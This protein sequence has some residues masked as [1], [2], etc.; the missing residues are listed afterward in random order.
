M[1]ENSELAA[2]LGF[3]GALTGGVGGA[4]TSSL[5]RKGRRH[6]LRNAVLSPLG[7]ATPK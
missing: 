4:L 2:I 3:Y 1:N 7:G 6:W 5:S